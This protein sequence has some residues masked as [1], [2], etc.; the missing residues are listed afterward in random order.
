[1]TKKQINSV[2]ILG[3]LKLGHDILLDGYE[4]MGD[5][6]LT[7][8][9]SINSIISITN[10]KIFGNIKLNKIS[11]W[12]PIG[13]ESTIIY[14]DAEFSDSHFFDQLFFN[15]VIFKGDQTL[16]LGTKFYKNLSFLSTIC[17]N[18]V[19]FAGAIFSDADFTGSRFDRDGIFTKAEFRQ[20]VSFKK[21]IFKKN[22]VF[23]DTVFNKNIYFDDARFE[24]ALILNATIVG[25]I[26]LT[27]NF[28]VMY[29]DWNRFKDHLSF[30]GD[31]I[32]PSCPVNVD[33]MK[34]TEEYQIYKKLIEN[35]KIIGRNDFAD[36]CYIKL[37]KSIKSKRESTILKFSDLIL[38][39]TCGYGARPSNIF[40]NIIFVV[41][42]FSIIYLSFGGLNGSKS[43]LSDLPIS[44]NSL[45][46]AS[47]DAFLNATC[48]SAMTF[49]GMT[50][51]LST[52]SN[53]Y[54]ELV[55]MLEVISG[56]FFLAILVGLVIYHITKYM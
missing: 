17:H 18:D 37:R 47:L 52:P 11:F 42:A 7:N 48:F 33:T 40:W 38:E 12:K 6:D 3:E 51:Y 53:T 10:S 54:W 35:F 43:I 13:F 56:Y 55:V 32:L 41:L 25:K 27:E 20:D 4:I 19:I 31:L 8:L 5:L 2:D 29:A 34:T 24:A 36:D 39:I 22:S 30:K 1:M 23:N 16:F 14:G 49:F 9:I 50:S 45:I 44:Q 28:K 21:C 46:L 26:V 15:S